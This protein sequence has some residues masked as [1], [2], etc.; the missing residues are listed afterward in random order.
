MMK[1]ALAI[2][3][4]CATASAADIQKFSE[5][6]KRIANATTP[7]EQADCHRNPLDQNAGGDHLAAVRRDKPLQN[8]P[9]VQGVE[10]RLSDWSFQSCSRLHFAGVASVSGGHFWHLLRGGIHPQDGFRQH[11]QPS[12]QAGRDLLCR[13]GRR[14]CKRGTRFE[15]PRF[16]ETCGFYR[17]FRQRP[18]E[19]AVTT[20]CV[21]EQTHLLRLHYDLLPAISQWRTK[22]L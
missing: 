2:L 22:K 11:D 20:G 1:T 18:I 13:K 17:R 15:M 4:V 10:K 14:R 21:E 12:D 7:A 9:G 6:L 8:R 5:D 3:L 19:R 16:L